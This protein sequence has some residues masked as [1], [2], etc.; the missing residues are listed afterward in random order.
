MAKNAVLKD[1]VV[2]RCERQEAG[3][4]GPWL[5][6]AELLRFYGTEPQDCNENQML[7]AQRH[8]SIIGVGGRWPE[9]ENQVHVGAGKP[10]ASSAKSY[11]L[12]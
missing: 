7:P 10:A 4:G 8:S 5:V 3:R 12:V 9:W 11:Q 2:V 1:D 6:P